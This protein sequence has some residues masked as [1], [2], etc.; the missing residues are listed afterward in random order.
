MYILVRV[1]GAPELQDSTR[2][3]STLLCFAILTVRRRC[4][5]GWV[6]CIKPLGM[7]LL[8]LDG[9]GGGGYGALECTYVTDNG[10][11]K[12]TLIDV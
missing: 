12:A 8:G 6:P 3:S 2:T 11:R 10:Q 1:G 9:V 7:K 5:V 4:F